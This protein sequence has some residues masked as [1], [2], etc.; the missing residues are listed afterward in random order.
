MGINYGPP[1]V[2]LKNLI[3]CLDAADKN[4]YPGSG[5]TWTNLMGPDNGTISGCT[6]SSAYGGILNFD[7]SN[8]KVDMTPT[9][10]GS[11]SELSVSI[12]CRTESNAGSYRCL[13]SGRSTSNNNDYSSGINIDQGSGVQTS[14]KVLSVEGAGR[15]GG[16]VDQMNDDIEF[17]NWTHIMVTKSTSTITMKINNNAQNNRSRNDVEMGLQYMCIGAR[18]YS[19]SN[20]GYFDGDIALI[21]LYNRVLTESEQEQNFN[22]HRGRFGV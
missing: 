17:N 4:S 5:T 22:S 21:H 15:I 8:D 2:V 11:L 9:A 7:G 6:F 16:S 18:Y 1:P 20:R 13:L 14:F 3:L 10:F 12:W 19:G